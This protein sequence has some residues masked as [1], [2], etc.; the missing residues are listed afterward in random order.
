MAGGGIMAVSNCVLR[1]LID[2]LGDLYAPVGSAGYPA[3]VI[4]VVTG[5]IG[6][7]SCSYNEFGGPGGATWRIEPAD[8]G[9]FPGSAA[10][11]TSHLPEHP[12]LSYHQ[13]TGDRS[14]R[15]ISDFLSDRQF[16]ALG[17]YRDFYAPS[18][19]SYQLAASLPGVA[20][21]TIGIALNRHDRDF[22]DQDRELLDL[23]RPH[24]A[25][26]AVIADRLGQPLPAVPLTADG[27]P[28][29]TPR[30]S[31]VME[32]VAEGSSDR[33]IGRRLGISTRTVHAHLRQ[34]YQALGVASRTEAVAR[35][36]VLGV[37][38]AAEPL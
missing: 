6:A 28:L 13:S 19:V 26:A 29:L 3:R 4:S 30:Q 36:A 22:R 32:L 12:V 5:L 20:G 7:D 10:I 35:L 17:L 37:S 8:V 25:Q 21:R 15:R 34:V 9:S 23:L 38:A 27:R 1:R 11:F 24:I 16:R 18:G 33:V 2:A 31:R 14:A